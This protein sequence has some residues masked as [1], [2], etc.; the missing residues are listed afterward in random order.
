M[1]AAL[2]PTV[3]DL[4]LWRRLVKQARIMAANPEGAAGDLKAAARAA[5]RAVAPSQDALVRFGAPLI[6]LADDFAGMG[7]IARACRAPELSWLAEGLSPLVGAEAAGGGAEV[8]A[9]R[10]RV[11]VVSGGV[12]GSKT[13][14]LANRLGLTLAPEDREDPRPERAPRADLDG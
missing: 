9:P 10:G 4:R 5:R 2:H 1:T 6:R 13:M 12:G 7:G 8:R 14:R 3:K 11:Q